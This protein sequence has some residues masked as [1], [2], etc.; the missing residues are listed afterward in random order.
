M[1]GNIDY[2][3]KPVKPR[4]FLTKPDR[5]VV[6]NLPDAYDIQL[7]RNI[8]EV[9]TLSFKAPYYISENNELIKSR[10]VDL[11]RAHYLIQLKFEQQTHW[12]MITTIK[13]SMSGTAMYKEVE[14]IGLP[15]ELSQRIIKGYTVESKGAIYVLENILADTRWTLNNVD[16]DFELSKRSF[17]FQDHTLLDCIYQVADTYDAIVEF[18][19]NLRSI[20]LIKPEFHGLYRGLRFSEGNLLNSFDKS[21]TTDEQV[22]RLRPEGKDGMTIN[23][24]NPTGQAYIAD[25]SYFMYPFQ[26]DDQGNVIQS[27]Y[28]MSDDLC[29][30]LLDYEQLIQQTENQFEQLRTERDTI[31]NTVTI[32]QKE[33]VTLH[34]QLLAVEQLEDNQLTNNNNPVM[35]I[36]HFHY[37]HSPLTRS[38]THLKKGHYALLCKLSNSSNIQVQYNGSNQSL[39]ANTWSLLGK[40]YVETESGAAAV[41]LSGNGA[42]EVMLQIV[43]LNLTEFETANNSQSILEKYCADYKRMQIASKQS[44]IAAQQD[45]LSSVLAEIANLKALLSESANFTSE[46]LLELEDYIREKDFKDDRY[47]EIT[48]LLQAGKDKFDEIRTPQL[49]LAINVVNFLE[50]IEQQ[51][52]WSYLRLG[53]EL[54][55]SYERIGIN[56]KAKLIGIAYNFDNQEIQLTIA[57]VTRLDDDAK[58]AEDYL[59]KSSYASTTL[60]ANKEKWTK[61][62]TDISDMSRIFDQFYEKT[63]EQINMSVNNTVTIDNRGITIYDPNDL[64]RFLR[65]TSGVL[66]LT[67]SGGQRFETAITPDGVIA[68]QV[69]GKIILGQRVVIGTDD[70]VW[71]TEGAQTTITDRC[72]REAMKLGLYEEN[73]DKFGMVINRYNDSTPCSPELINKIIADSEDGFKIQQWNGTQFVDKFYVDSNGLLY[74]VDMTAKRLTITS[75]TDELLL[76][77]YTK[78]MNIGKFE[79][80][81][82]DGKLTALEKLQV[83]GEK[84]RIISEYA[85]LLAQAEIYKTTTRDSSIRIDTVN[86]TQA[87]E[88]LLAYLAPLLIDMDETSDIDRTAFIEHFKAYYDEVT[89]IVNAINDSIKYSS[90]QLGSVYNNTVIDALNGVMSTRNDNTYRAIMNGTRGFAIQKNTAAPNGENWINVFSVNTDGFLTAEGIKVNNSL[91]TNGGIEG[92]YI[93]L[94]NNHDGVMKLYPSEGFWAGHESIEQA[95]LV[96]TPTGKLKLKGKAGQFLLDTETGV[97]DLS[98]IDIIGAGRISADS[99]MV[100]TIIAGIGYISNLTVNKLIT[101]GRTDEVNG[102]N[103]YVHVEDNAIRLKTGKISSRTQA[104]ANGKPLYWTDSSKTT[105]T[106]SPTSY[107]VWNLNVDEKT[108]FLLDHKGSGGSAYPRMAWGQGDSQ[109][110]D[111]SIND[112]IANV[113]SGRGFIEKPEGSFDFAYYNSHFA[114]E[115][116]LRLKDDGVYLYSENQ[117]I[118]AI[119]KNLEFNLTTDGQLSITNTTGTKIV[120]S[121][122]GNITLESSDSINVKSSGAIKFDGSSYDFA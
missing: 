18:D 42:S 107:P 53:D 39:S 52:K 14:T 57:N 71:M 59:K 88:S 9:D 2:L 35:F 74:A 60:S 4:L 110:T 66:G 70:G 24:I 73:P 64:L 12:F 55:L 19:S 68:E 86:F 100:N 33:L 65:I 34:S 95:P 3:K 109:V 29:H 106:E 48:D 45:Q 7:Q 102:V 83:L 85:K 117:K 63:T 49:A 115:R 15:F 37:S 113:K 104:T 21:S 94:R 25:Y 44:E 8:N 56:V 40:L 82:V 62:I 51:G 116:S 50:I 101:F 22:T 6:A 54:K 111:P 43:N 81:I 77:S 90:V 5:S 112:G 28:Y 96:I 78:Y 98:N 17:E 16:P 58:K 36:D 114:R 80:I 75:G 119:A 92:A 47:V 13:E 103:D 108:K 69:L 76:D 26:R 91:M 11:L 38:F 46:Q 27:S 79:N 23:A 99:L 32:K 31:A 105:A 121:P 97:L 67:K 30:A 1:L 120:I 61:S 87:Y 122:S 89:H 10:Y 118:S 84:T 41:H 93:V 72:H 20:D